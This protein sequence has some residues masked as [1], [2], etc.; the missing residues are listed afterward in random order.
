MKKLYILF[1]SILICFTLTGC[2]QLEQW[3]AAMADFAESAKVSMEEASMKN[4]A[5]SLLS[6]IS[7]SE[8]SLET[9]D[10]SLDLA[11]AL[12]EHEKLMNSEPSDFGLFNVGVEGFVDNFLNTGSLNPA[13]QMER[14]QAKSRRD[15]ED[16]TTDL[17]TSFA[18][19][20]LTMEKFNLQNKSGDVPWLLIV[21]I[22]IVAIVFVVMTLLKKLRTPKIKP[23]EVTPQEP[24][25]RKVEDVDSELVLMDVDNMKVVRSLCAK[26]GLDVDTELARCNGDVQQLVNELLIMS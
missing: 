25:K 1:C 14:L 15:I 16:M 17:D 21:L 3:K 18:K 19:D 23:I 11:D 9:A 13:T 6:K 20:K 2:E 22:A 7:S 4:E 5:N 26:H 12:G 8:V 24:K 10:L